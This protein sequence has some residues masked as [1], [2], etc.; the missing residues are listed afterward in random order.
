[1]AEPQAPQEA[2]PAEQV[3][4]QMRTMNSP[5]DQMVIRLDPPELGQVRITL[6]MDGEGMR[7]VLRVENPETLRQLQRESEGLM[8]RLAASGVQVRRLQVLPQEPTAERNFDDSFY[9]QNADAQQFGQSGGS[10]SSAGEGQ[11]SGEYDRTGHGFADT[12]PIP[13][14]DADSDADPA[15]GAGI[16]VVM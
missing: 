8:N 14:P 3:F 9:R 15:E 2:N 6:E 5:G 12:E 7:G 16:N 1:A 13:D 10:G 11:E 4:V